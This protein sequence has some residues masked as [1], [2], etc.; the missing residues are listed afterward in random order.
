[1]Q[2][3]LMAYP[4]RVPNNRTLLLMA[5]RQLVPSCIPKSTQIHS[6]LVGQSRCGFVGHFRESV[7]ESTQVFMTHIGGT[8][9]RPRPDFSG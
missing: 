6:L 4:K 2:R 5:Y 8:E 7:V 1:M 3:D 9:L